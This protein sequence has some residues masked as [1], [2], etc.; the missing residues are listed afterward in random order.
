VQAYSRASEV[1]VMRY[2]RGTIVAVRRQHSYMLVGKPFC[3]GAGVSFFLFSPSQ[4]SL[5]RSSPNF[6]IFCHMFDGDTDLQT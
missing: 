1:T 3:Y 5:G 6:G 2:K 4:R